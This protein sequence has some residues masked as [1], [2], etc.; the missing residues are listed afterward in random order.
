M[1][2]GQ[3]NLGQP[4][5]AQLAALQNQLQGLMNSFEQMNK[6][7]N[8]DSPGDRAKPMDVLTVAGDDG[9]RKF[10]MGMPNNSSGIVFND[11]SELYFY[12]LK[13]DA[14]GVPAPIKKCPFTIEDMTEE[15]DDSITKK[16]LDDMRNEIG[17]IKSMLSQLPKQPTYRMEQKG[18]RGSKPQEG[19]SHESAS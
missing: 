7:R 2:F 11:G 9:A 12:I 5:S 19:V 18:Q 6:L 1:D 3:M 13:K 10:L 17:E 8:N 15:V 16:D 14:N 4:S